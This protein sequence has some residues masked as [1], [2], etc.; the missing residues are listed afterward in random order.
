MS[1]EAVN[2]VDKRG[3]SCYNIA[4]AGAANGG[5]MDII[6]QI[7]GIVGAGLSIVSYQSKN[8]KGMF[9][10]KGISGLMFAVNFFLL[11]S[12]TGAVL[13][14]INFVRSACVASKRS[15]YDKL[16]FWGVNAL[17]VLA[18]ILTYGG[19]LSILVTA[20]QLVGTYAMWD[21]NGKKLRILQFFVVSPCWLI[22]NIVAFSIG[23][24]ITEAVNLG[25]VVVSVL[26]FG[27]NGFVEDISKEDKSSNNNAE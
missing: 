14:V 25:S 19:W 15:K 20:A 17:Y 1:R 3:G 6:A 9:L 2:F 8:N 4:V 11:G 21:R 7:A 13:N 27:I 10:M 12:Y 5:N 24:I 18:G 23:G 26:R 22:H 16:L